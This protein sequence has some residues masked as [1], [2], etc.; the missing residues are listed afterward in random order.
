MSSD[1]EDGKGPGQFS[2]QGCAEA[3]G[4]AAAAREGQEV[5]D[6]LL[7]FVGGGIEGGRYRPDTE[8]NPPEAE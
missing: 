1:K 5:Q 8:F 7:P 6:L 3:H 4:E 2:V